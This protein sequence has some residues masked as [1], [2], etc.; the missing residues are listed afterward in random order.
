MQAWV[1]WALFAG[2]AIK[3]P[4]FPLHTWLPLAHVQ[5]PTAGSVF[6][7]GILLKIGA[8]GFLAFQLADAAYASAVF[9]PWLVWLSI[10]GI[11]YGALVA[12]RRETS[13]V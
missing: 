2:F 12:L 10:A 4:L 13:S 1:F 8:Y 7:A 11:I 3:V 6:L 5:A 9:A